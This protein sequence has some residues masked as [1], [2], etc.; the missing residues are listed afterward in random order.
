MAFTTA[1]GKTE[2]DRIVATWINEFRSI[3]HPYIMGSGCPCVL[4]MGSR[5][6]RS[7]PKA[8]QSFIW[9]NG[10]TPIVITYDSYGVP[11]VLIG[12]LPY[13]MPGSPQ[14]QTKRLDELQSKGGFTIDGDKLI[15]DLKYNVNDQPLVAEV[16]PESMA[17]DQFIECKAPLSTNAPGKRIVRKG[18]KEQGRIGPSEPKYD[19]APLE[20]DGAAEMERESDVPK[21]SPGPNTLDELG[22]MTD[23]DDE[24]VESAGP[25]S[26]SSAKNYT[27]TIEK[28]KDSEREILGSDGTD[29]PTATKDNEPEITYDPIT[30]IPVLDKDK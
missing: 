16:N 4:S 24:V 27:S 15:I 2:A 25:S 23:T 6:N 26:S 7:G 20:G 1:N 13:I 19:L 28:R 8:G 29:L 10:K 30:T 17:D 21:D 12:D 5:C 3:A 18:P 9:I 11:L 22:Y 14:C